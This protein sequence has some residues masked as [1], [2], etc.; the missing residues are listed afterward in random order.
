MNVRVYLTD[1][2][3]WQLWP[4]FVGVWEQ[5]RFRCNEALLWKQEAYRAI[6]ICLPEMPLWLPTNS[7]RPGS[8]FHALFRAPHGG[9]KNSVACSGVVK[10][11]P[12]SQ[13]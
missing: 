8:R 10:L 6:R 12:D 9:Y 1:Y 11:L 3:T 7:G 5:D 13:I 2:S 4:C